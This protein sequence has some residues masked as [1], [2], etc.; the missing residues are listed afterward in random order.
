MPVQ[1]SKQRYIGLEASREQCLKFVP[2]EHR[3]HKSIVD[4]A[5]HNQSST[6]SFKYSIFLSVIMMVTS[7]IESK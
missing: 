1:V 3:L 7:D 2:K 5:S 4:V 6:V